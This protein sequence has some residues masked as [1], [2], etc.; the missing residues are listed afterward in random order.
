MEIN[1]PLLDGR[2][3][4]V[5]KDEYFLYHLLVL[6]LFHKR[7]GLHWR[8]GDSKV[9]TVTAGN[10]VLELFGDGWTAERTSFTS[11]LTQSVHRLCGGEHASTAEQAFALAIQNTPIRINVLIEH[12]LGEGNSTV[13]LIPEGASTPEVWE[14]ARDTLRAFTDRNRHMAVRLHGSGATFEFK[15]PRKARAR[16]GM[17]KALRRIGHILRLRSTKGRDESRG[18]QNSGD[19]EFREHHL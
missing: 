14:S 2:A 3:D 7:A 18:D 8:N 17:L 12:E 15:D 19:T 11:G 1:L 4:V 9:F 6:C 10:E 13:R 16:P 5:E